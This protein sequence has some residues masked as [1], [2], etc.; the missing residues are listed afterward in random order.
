MAS[1]PS[2]IWNQDIKTTASPAI[3]LD[4]ENQQNQA[5]V[6]AP[7]AGVMTPSPW[8]SVQSDPCAMWRECGQDPAPTPPGSYE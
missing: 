6:K 7:G 8:Y 5:I 1:A 3:P 4:T 2:L